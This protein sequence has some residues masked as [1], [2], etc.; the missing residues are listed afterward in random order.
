[1]RPN[2]SALCIAVAGF[3]SPAPALEY[4]TLVT[5][6]V[7]NDYGHSAPVTLAAGDV[8]RVVFAGANL[9]DGGIA[10]LSVQIGEK[11]FR[12][13]LGSQETNPGA[14]TGVENN[15]VIVGPAV[16]KL[17]KANNSTAFPGIMTLAIT[18]AGEPSPS[19]PSTAVVIPEDA[20]GEFQVILESSTDLV[21]WT[22][23]MPGTYG[24][25]TQK[26]FFRTRVVRT[27]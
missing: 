6:A 24:G 12:I 11:S 8:A 7:P 17:S 15:P 19:I 10:V 5:E 26:R 18:P 3:F 4:I 21:T 14:F 2:L 13:N 27:N 23:A 16:L 25:S 1:M 9:M 22:Q 20:N